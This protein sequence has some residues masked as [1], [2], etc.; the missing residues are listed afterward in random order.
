MNKYNLH[1][2]VSDM[3]NEVFLNNEPNPTLF[4]ANYL[5]DL[6]GNNKEDKYLEEIKGL[7]AL[8]LQHKEQLYATFDQNQALKLKLDA[9]ER[10]FCGESSLHAGLPVS[11]PFEYDL[12]QPVTSNSLKDKP[13]ERQVMVWLPKNNEFCL[14]AHPN[15]RPGI[16]DNDNLAQ[17]ENNDENDKENDN[18]YANLPAKVEMPNKAIHETVQSICRD[19][20]RP[21][22]STVESPLQDDETNRHDEKPSE[23]SKENISDIQQAQ[24]VVPKINRYMMADSSTETGKLHL[25]ESR[26]LMDIEA[27]E[28]TQVLSY[29]DDD[30]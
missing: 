1:Y 12:E 27:C 18:Q 22:S 16:K 29:S 6:N 23:A 20:M 4:M 15:S 11:I 26:C 8:L 17:A 14:K 5:L 2:I 28:S 10:Q 7:K 30:E 21:D 3:L 19:E 25:S 24:V 9:M 13:V